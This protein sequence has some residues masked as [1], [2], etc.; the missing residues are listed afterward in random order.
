MQQA[1]YPNAIASYINIVGMIITAAA[2]LGLSIQFFSSMTSGYT[3]LAFLSIGIAAELGKY[4]SVV[5]TTTHHY[6][7]NRGL[8]I[9][10][11]MVTVLLIAVS[12]MGS[13][14]S[15]LGN[16]SLNKQSTIES[17][18]NDIDRRIALEENNI[19]E[20]TKKNAQTVG[21]NPSRESLNS[22]TEE[23]NQLLESR[24]AALSSRTRFETL[25]SAISDE[26]GISQDSVYRFLSIMVACLL[27]GLCLL[28]AIANL[29][30]KESLPFTTLE[31]GGSGEGSKEESEE[32][33]G[34]EE[35]FRLL[36]EAIQSKEIKPNHKNIR[37]FMSV[38]SNKVSE[39]RKRLLDENIV[40]EGPRSSLIPV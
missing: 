7:G 39:I 15:L 21:V 1:L 10:F 37:M 32:D 12:I 38:K 17:R 22:L 35:R 33:I 18:L 25:A 28:F 4:C 3:S 8:V 16:K 26:K 14:A 5:M 13:V 27:E 40:I 36:I 11:G 29:V 24:D 6:R 19:K 2:S 9:V 34:E 23:K 30:S 31:K 20:A